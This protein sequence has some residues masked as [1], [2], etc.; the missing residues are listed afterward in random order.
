MT[1][2]ISYGATVRRTSNW[3][4]KTVICTGQRQRD[5]RW[6]VHITHSG[7]WWWWV[8]EWV[9]AEVLHQFWWKWVATLPW[10]PRDIRLYFNQHCSSARVHFCYALNTVHRSGLFNLLK[11]DHTPK[12]KKS[13]QLD[14]SRIWILKSL[15]CDLRFL[16]RPHWIFGTGSGASSRS[17]FWEY[18]PANFI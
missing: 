15:V 11:F 10:G 17:C 14:W 9:A 18:M 8:T 12:K 6:D 16:G 2:I 7:V 3:K 1:T 5:L 13:R 4:N